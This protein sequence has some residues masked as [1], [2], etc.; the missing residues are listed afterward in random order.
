MGSGFVQLNEEA[1]GAAQ[2]MSKLESSLAAL[3]FQWYQWRLLLCTGCFACAEY[4]DTMGL[5]FLMPVS[6]RR[7]LSHSISNYLLVPSS[8]LLLLL[9]LLLFLLLLL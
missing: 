2:A 4:I 9:L 3:G 5:A 1:D 8:S 7:I 6:H